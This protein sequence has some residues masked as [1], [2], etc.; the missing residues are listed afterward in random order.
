MAIILGNLALWLS[1]LFSISQLISLKKNRNRSIISISVIGLLIVSISSFLILIYSY[2]ISDFS[3][4]NVFQ[5]S[6]T[7]KP[8][9][10][11][12]SAA[13][14]N[15]EGS[16]LLW[17]V[18]LTLFNFLI[19]KLLNKKNSTFIL[20]TLEI[21]IV[22]IIGFILFTILTSNP[23][24]EVIP[25][26]ENGL[27]FNPILQD[28]ALAI[29]PPL[30]YIG[31]VGFSA[32]FSMSV[33]TLILNDNQKIPWYNY[34]KPFVLVAWTFL[35]IGIALGS[36]WAYYELGW[37]GWW[38]WDPVENASFMPWLLGTALLHSLIIVQKKKSLQTW[39]LLLGI[40]TFL[41]SVIGTFLVRS[42][43]LTSVHT[44]A[45]DPSRGIYILAL[46]I[47][48]GTYALFLFGTRSKNFS[49]NN[50]FSFFSKEGSILMN[51][52]F[53]V[54]VCAIVFLGTIYPLLIEA[55]TNNKISVGEPYFNS[56]VVPIII[57]TILIMGVAPTMNWGE[58][59]KLIFFKR[60]IPCI[61]ITLLMSSFIFLIYRSY[62]II[63]I[64]GIII[65]FWII[66]NNI[67]ILIKKDK[68]L[69]LGMVV[70]HL[71][72]GLIILGVTGSSIW[73]QEKIINMNIKNEV[74]IEKYN[75]IFEKIN[76]VM[77][78]NY[79][80]LQ[81]DFVVYDDKKNIVTKLKPEN[82]FYPITNIFTSEVSIHTN[83]IRD[84]Y[85]V[86]GKGNSKDGWTVKIYYNPLVIWIWIGALFVFFG[87]I[88]STK[89]NLKNQKIIYK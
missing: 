83:L 23:F 41:L 38:F 82:R 70:A 39:V 45:L 44:F 28:P 84:L 2:L 75:I 31:Y 27:G 55:L 9:I 64:L 14:G 43:I 71:G 48:L 16:M 63:G 74:K 57:P 87:G 56:T 73:Q 8:L 10:Y 24:Q 25:V 6:H 76:E 46:T 58:N 89:N 61:V 20:K 66:S 11:K 29:H 69:S 78:E 51:N 79:I 3:I 68:T 33:A 53:M 49:N 32:V 86:L 62:S 65:G 54:I 4:L 59:K 19:Y 5:N 67:I 26:P 50:Y 72:I 13:W 34:M 37:G 7:T 47:F 85:I 52:I 35:S 40:L 42:G 36:L 81:G 1:L 88:I 12:L 30:L 18:V 17:I 22:I 15:H 21:Q 80:A 60:T 77:S